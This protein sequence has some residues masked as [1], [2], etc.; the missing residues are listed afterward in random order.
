M[1]LREKMNS[2]NTI[3]DSAIHYKIL[4]TQNDCLEVWH[5][6]FKPGVPKW[7]RSG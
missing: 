3:N 6:L 1:A 5:L 7:V 4:S 2:G